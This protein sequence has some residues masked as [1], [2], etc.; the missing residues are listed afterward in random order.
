MRFKVC[1][2]GFR[3]LGLV[4]EGFWGLRVQAAVLGLIS[5]L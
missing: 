1:T 4:T 3:S 5:A 2:L